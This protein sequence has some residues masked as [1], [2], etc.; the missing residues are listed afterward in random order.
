MDSFMLIPPY[1]PQRGDFAHGNETGGRS[2]CGAKFPDDKPGPFSISNVE[3]NTN[4]SQLFAWPNVRG[5]LAWWPSC[6]WVKKGRTGACTVVV[7]GSNRSLMITL[8]SAEELEEYHCLRT[9]ELDSVIK[10]IQVLYVL[11]PMR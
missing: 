9:P 1:N 4:D 2:I 8:C 11:G 3:K 6:H 7:N 10:I 5:A